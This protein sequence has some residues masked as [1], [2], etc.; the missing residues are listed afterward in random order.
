LVISWYYTIRRMFVLSLRKSNEDI[1]HSKQFLKKG[2][3]WLDSCFYV[4]IQCVRIGT[5][6]FRFVSKIEP[7]GRIEPDTSAVTSWS[8]S[9]RRKVNFV[10][11]GKKQTNF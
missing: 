1:L 6:F 4:E 7:Q 3:I 11:V 5:R 2:N 8:Y 9:V 10:L